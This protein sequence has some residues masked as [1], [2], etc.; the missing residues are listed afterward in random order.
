[1][2]EQVNA[3]RR[4]YKIMFNYRDDSG[5]ASE[6]RPLPAHQRTR[7]KDK[8]EALAAAEKLNL[9]CPD[10]VFRAISVKETPI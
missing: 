3:A 5:Q 6:Y 9:N 2:K 10:R 1:M 4:Y 7:Y 8:A